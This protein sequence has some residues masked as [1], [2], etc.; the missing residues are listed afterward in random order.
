MG[1]LSALA[2]RDTVLTGSTPNGARKL[3]D[4]WACDDQG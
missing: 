3:L 1:A 2:L 4:R